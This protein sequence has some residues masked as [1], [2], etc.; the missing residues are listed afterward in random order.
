MLRDASASARASL[1]ASSQSWTSPVLRH[2]AVNPDSLSG[3]EPSSGAVGPL[4]ARHTISPSRSRIAA[5][6]VAP[7]AR[8]ACS[9]ISL[10]TI[11][12]A[13]SV[14]SFGDTSAPLLAAKSAASS[15]KSVSRR[16]LGGNLEGPR[17]GMGRLDMQSEAANQD[18]RTVLQSTGIRLRG[19]AVAQVSPQN[20]VL[21]ILAPVQ[22]CEPNCNIGGPH[23]LA[24]VR[25]ASL[26]T[27]SV[28]FFDISPGRRLPSRN[29]RIW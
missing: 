21:S 3:C 20:G 7:V 28:C 2:S 18:S 27:D 6:P 9:T 29:G 13:S 8:Q 15:V 1:R 16:S 22:Q 14:E 11:S 26:I 17:F 25:F 24:F 5:A 12:S 10:S 4:V 23:C 19:G